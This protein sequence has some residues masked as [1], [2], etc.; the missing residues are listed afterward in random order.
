MV[1]KASRAKIRE[2]KHRRL[3]HPAPDFLFF[4]CDYIIILLIHSFFYRI[5]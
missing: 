4:H 1:N 2:N 5:K 3:R